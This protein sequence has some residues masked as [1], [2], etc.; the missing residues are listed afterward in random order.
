MKKI[1]KILSGIIFAVLMLAGINFMGLKT[2]TSANAAA[3]TV[4]FKANGGTINGSTNDY[5]VTTE[6]DGSILTANVPKPIYTGYVFIGWFRVGEATAVN[7]LTETFDTI[8][9]LNALWANKTNIYTISS[10]GT[11]YSVVG[12]TNQTGLT[13]LVC[14]NIATIADVV[15]NI[16]TDMLS[17]TTASLAFDNITI[18]NDE[19]LNLDFANV[20]LSGSI[21]STATTAAINLVPTTAGSTYTFNE[22]NLTNNYAD[23]LVDT[24]NSAQT[25]NVS[26]INSTFN[27][28]NTD[29]SYAFWFNDLENSISFSDPEPDDSIL[30]YT[31]THSSEFMFNYTDNLTIDLSKQLDNSGQNKIKASIDYTYDKVTVLT[32]FHMS[33][34]GRFMFAPLDDFYTCQDG[35]FNKAL[36]IYTYLNITFDLNGG[37]YAGGYTLPRF[38]YKPS[39]EIKFADGS[40]ITQTHKTF[41]GWFGKITLSNEQKLALGV[42]E[43]T[44][45]YD[46]V[47]LLKFKSF[48]Y[49]PEKFAECFKT[50]TETFDTATAFVGYN[51]D[52][53][54]A[55]ANHI[56]LN[57]ATELDLNMSFVALWKDVL[58][59][60]SFNSNGGTAVKQIIEPFGTNITKPTDPTKT[61]YTFAGWFKDIT[62][63]VP[64]NFTPATTIKAENITLYANWTINTYTVYFV[65]ETEPAG[66]QTDVFDTP[67]NFPTN[68]AN[69]DTAPDYISKKGHHLAGWSLTNGS[70]ELYT[71]STIPGENITLYAVWE[72]SAYK[73]YF[74]TNPKR[75]TSL[76]VSN[77]PEVITANYGSTITKP[78]NLIADGYEFDGWYTSDDYQFAFS[79]TT[80]PDY[81]QMAYAKWIIK[82]Y[83]IS[84]VT[85]ASII[86]PAT[87]DFNEKISI[88]LQPT[89]PGY[90][91][92]GWYQDQACTTA[93]SFETMP[94]ENITIYA[95]WT[96]KDTIMIEHPN[97]SMV[98]GKTT[99][100]NIE[101]S[102]PGFYVQYYVGG[103]WTHLI[104]TEVGKYNVKITRAEDPDG[105]TYNY[106]AYSVVLENAFEVVNKTLDLT[107]LI[108]VLAILIIAEIAVII[109]VKRMQKM[110]RQEAITL[111]IALPMGLIPTNQFVL[112]MVFGAL[113]LFGF[114]LLIF[115]LVK[116]HRIVPLPN[117]EHSIYDTR[118]RIETMKDSSEDSAI[119]SK[120]DDLLKSEG[121]EQP[122]VQVPQEDEVRFDDD[123]NVFVNDDND[124]PKYN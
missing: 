99:G 43:N 57:L 23:I 80:M 30:E 19:V 13:Y 110:K 90:S 2:S 85:N 102:I 4:T 118:N 66:H 59:S 67:I 65:N 44:Y 51:Y 29:A 18:L 34:I 70:T 21:T 94:A 104:P 111:A 14:K 82:Q 32:N 103:E 25:L 28:T 46:T 26:L 72:I 45:Y 63:L 62:F 115:E 52:E 97:Q 35:H 27:T 107:W 64:F 113:A 112:L 3:V 87:Y 69:N 33:N 37:E 120:V 8:T 49:A 56:F 98:V 79:F 15:S 108:I 22:F 117:S 53:L 73:I 119:A 16:K 39:A 76:V 92:D 42:S 47:A 106:K 124:T 74:D 95:K 114:I 121:F 40:Q 9:T 101:S 31:A 75:I 1:S 83:T 81:D 88:P 17:A 12:K 71:G 5:Q 100:F 24:T 91:F 109:I 78:A 58:Y 50:S 11:N 93:F 89:N 54:N 6:E 96:E 38:E 10:D 36:T 123:G 84:F 86:Q 7:F 105:S 48:N 61:G 55:N 68:D 60:I 41:V 20:T 122:S 116:L 77:I